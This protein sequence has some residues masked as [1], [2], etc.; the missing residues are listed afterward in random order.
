MK[1]VFSTETSGGY[2]KNELQA[3]KEATDRCWIAPAKGDYTCTWATCCGIQNAVHS[4]SQRANTVRPFACLWPLPFK[5][6]CH[7]RRDIS[8]GKVC[9]DGGTAFVGTCVNLMDG[10][11]PRKVQKAQE[12]CYAVG[13][14]RIHLKGKTRKN[15]EG[16][17]KEGCLSR[18]SA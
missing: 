10:R 6:A 5:N 15:I 7:H 18:E 3:V 11:M 14:L 4:V 16:T 13:P 1:T 8:L 2:S 17:L 12:V 9:A